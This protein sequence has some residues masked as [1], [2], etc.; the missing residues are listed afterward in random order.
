MMIYCLKREREREREREVGRMVVNTN[1]DKGEDK[2]SGCKFEAL[3]KDASRVWLTWVGLQL[4]S[5]L[6]H[7]RLCHHVFLASWQ[8]PST[9]FY[10]SDAPCTL[11]LPNDT[12]FL[13]APVMLPY[14]LTW[15]H[16]DTLCMT[17]QIKMLVRHS[18]FRCTTS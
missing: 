12:P 5:W 17:Q 16:P 9:A 15:H 3:G 11:P 14:N 13:L 10:C 7:G 4:S 1:I 18:V 6:R 2:G 8:L